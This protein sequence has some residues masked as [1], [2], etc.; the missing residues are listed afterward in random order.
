MNILPATSKCCIGLFWGGILTLWS[1]LVL[2]PKISLNADG[3][4]I[5]WAAALP[6]LLGTLVSIPEGLSYPLQVLFIHHYCLQYSAPPPLPLPLECF[7]SHSNI[8]P[9]SPPVILFSVFFILFSF[10]FFPEN[11]SILTNFSQSHQTPNPPLPSHP[12]CIV[13]AF[14]YISTYLYARTATDFR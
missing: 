5:L 13:L 6:G 3:C 10:F 2:N 14:I 7:V 1:T 4:K 12:T 9:H 8:C 11:T